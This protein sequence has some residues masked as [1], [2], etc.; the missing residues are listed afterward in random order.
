MFSFRCIGVLD[1]RLNNALYPSALHAGVRRAVIEQTF[2]RIP[3][4]VPYVRDVR[5][6]G[7]FPEKTIFAANFALIIG[8]KSKV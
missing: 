6:R 5:C 7:N 3:F 4:R 8:V 1:V 2:P